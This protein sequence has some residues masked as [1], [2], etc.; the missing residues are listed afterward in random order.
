MKVLIVEDEYYA[1]KRLV[2]MVL[3]WDSS[4]IITGDVETGNEAITSISQEEPD[5]VLTDIR[6]P[7][8]DGLELSRYVMDNHPSVF[9]VILSGY[10]DFEFAQKAICFNVKRYI[11]K[12]IKREDLHACLNE[13]KEKWEERIRERQQYAKMLNRMVSFRL[14]SAIYELNR[15]DESLAELLKIRKK[16]N[17]YWVIVF[18]S[19]GPLSEQDVESLEF[20]LQGLLV[21]ES[22]REGYGFLNPVIH[23]EWIGICF[24]TKY[25]ERYEVPSMNTA[26]VVRDLLSNL[27]E[28]FSLGVSR[29][30]SDASSLSMGYRE[31]KYALAQH[32]C[33]GTNRLYEHEDLEESKDYEW[34]EELENKLHQE[35]KAGRA[36]VV[37]RL[38]H[39]LF[40]NFYEENQVSVKQL[41][42][43]HSRIDAILR[44]EINIQMISDMPKK[45]IDEF[46]SLDQLVDG[47]T[48]LVDRLC[49]RL[50]ATEH[51]GGENQD[52]IN[53]LIAYVKENYA[54][55]ISLDL[56]A[57][58]RYY[59]NASYLS[60]LFKSKTGQGFSDFLT[61]CRMKKAK[62]L[63]ESNWFSISEIAG[64]VGYTQSSHFIQIFK[65]HYGET[66][67]EYK[68]TCKD[69]KKTI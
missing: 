61:S 3:D 64:L 38:I 50:P 9:V 30:H 46:A 13:L 22:N 2:K 34:K 8:M 45:E 49:E 5:L 58:H 21:S 68:S 7:E 62:E 37:K 11:L 52:L 55:E 42:Q 54:C 28:R 63:I 29:L 1:R 53:D 20:H 33:H 6:M 31:A 25:G 35:L 47:L 15:L 32:L 17:G 56:L 27:T 59:L 12:P 44:S 51:K 4:I 67:G 40:T 60:R 41:V 69:V 18:K 43:L 16:T 24:S 19:Y 36:V 26:N 48:S 66:P 10:A 65:K 57:K 23:N 39:S 14:T